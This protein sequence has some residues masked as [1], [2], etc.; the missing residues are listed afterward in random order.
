MATPAGAGSAEGA[1]T[2]AGAGSAE[3]AATPAAGAAA[4]AATPA[5][6]AAAGAD[7]TGPPLIELRGVTVRRGGV[8]ALDDVTLAVAPGDRVAILGPSGAGKTTLLGVMAATVDP[9]AGEIRLFGSRPPRRRRERRRLASRIGM[10]PQDPPLVG[11]LRVV[12]NVNA[13]MLGRWSTVR[14]LVSLAFPAGRP[15]VDALLARLELDG[16]ADRRTDELSGG[17][18]RRVAVART[19]RQGP[20]LLLADEPASS[21]DPRTGDLVV[22]AV[23]ASPAAAVVVA[24]HD[25]G[26]ARRHA[27]RVV[28]LRAGRICFDVPPDELD[29]GRLERLYAGT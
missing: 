26:L 13:G 9:D 1:A 24:L 10:V 17:Q 19:L 4:G 16:L 18:R 25:P 21:L 14:A 5:A 3:G 20:D 11:S 27:T 23:V 28:G 22:D 8:V 29:T 15:T 7:T 12:H 6:G 2:P